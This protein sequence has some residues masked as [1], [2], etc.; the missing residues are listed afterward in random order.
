MNRRHFLLY[1]SL[2]FA[3]GMLFITNSCQKKDALPEP[4]TEG[5]NTFACKINGKVWIANGIPTGNKAIEV[6]FKQLNA[7][8]F[9]LFIHTN[10]VEKDRV[11]LTLPKA[12]KGVNVLNYTLN[13]PFGVYYDNKFQLF[14]SRDANPGKVV[15]T[16]LDTINRIISGTFE[17]EGM[18]L[19][20]KQK[21]SVTEGRFDIDLDNL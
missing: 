18:E 1:L 2:L 3:V 10:G 17:F 9:Y 13:E 19:V 5:L 6:E 21:V 11:Q 7:D 8:T 20:N 15:I 14:F 4:T 16:K 12:V